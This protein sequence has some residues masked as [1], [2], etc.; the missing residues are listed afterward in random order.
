VRS[1]FTYVYNLVVG[2]SLGAK[3]VF[4]PKVGGKLNGFWSRYT[5]ED[6]RYQS[7]HEVIIKEWLDP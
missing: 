6:A 7:G 1:T 4:A 3:L 2:G 5:W